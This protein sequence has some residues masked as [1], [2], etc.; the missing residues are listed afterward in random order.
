MA[1][2]KDFY[3][4]ETPKGVNVYQSYDAWV[5]G[6]Q[7]IHQ[8]ETVQD[9][10]SWI[11]QEL[12]GKF[13]RVPEGV[14]IT[15]YIKTLPFMPE[16]GESLPEYV[17]KSL[18]PSPTWDLMKPPES[19][20]G[21]E[22][23]DETAKRLKE[24]MTGGNFILKEKFGEEGWSSED[25]TYLGGLIHVPTRTDYLVQ[26]N[27]FFEWRKPKEITTVV[28]MLHRRTEEQELVWDGELS[29]EEGEIANK[30]LLE[31]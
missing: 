14:D 26:I 9:A 27:T 22:V 8:A 3:I 21:R 19:E 12:E 18:Y 13:E 6:E 28:V 24:F 17:V 16:K 10:E 31:L 11:D 7:P 20:Y 4:E 29:F 15:E 1:I 23:V 2:Y 5:N 30:M 25:I